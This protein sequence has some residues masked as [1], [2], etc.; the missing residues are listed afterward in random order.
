MARGRPQESNQERENRA[1][2]WLTDTTEFSYVVFRCH[3]NPKSLSFDTNGALNASFTIP[4]GQVNE[5]LA[6]RY[7][8]RDRLPLKVRVEVSDE[9]QQL[10]DKQATHLRSLPSPDDDDNIE[11]EV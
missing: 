9:F 10:R 6:L 1:A 2:D 3:L 7:L 5:A 8:V 4:P 11:E